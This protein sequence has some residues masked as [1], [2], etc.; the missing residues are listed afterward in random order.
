MKQMNEITLEHIRHLPSNGQ[1]T[2]SVQLPDDEQKKSWFFDRAV[3]AGLIEMANSPT[4]GWNINPTTVT[5]IIAILLFFG[6]ICGWLWNV[7]YNQGI[8]DTET[9]QLMER[10]AIAEKEAKQAKDLSLSAASR[11]GHE[12]EEDKKETKKK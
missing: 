5:S 11:A 8:K 12:T 9:R 4:K 7:A 1:V 3:D 2:E 6:A 10:L